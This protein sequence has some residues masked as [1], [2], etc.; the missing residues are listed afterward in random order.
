MN[1]NDCSIVNSSFSL[2]YL[3]ILHLVNL[4]RFSFMNRSMNLEQK[5]IHKN[6]LLHLNTRCDD[7]GRDTQFYAFIPHGI[8][9]LR[10]R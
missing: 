2:K 6:G 8:V 5:L 3:K 10:M 7:K 1:E 4:Q 9:I